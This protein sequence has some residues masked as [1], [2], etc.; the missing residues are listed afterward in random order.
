MLVLSR[1]L[2]EVVIITS[3]NNQEVEV[4]VKVIAVS[5]NQVKLAFKAPD[6]IKILREEL[7]NSQSCRKR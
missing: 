2:D 4:A 1:K 5:G 6:D 7:A 3:N